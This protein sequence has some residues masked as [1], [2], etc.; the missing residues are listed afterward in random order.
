MIQWIWLGVMVYLLMVFD[1]F[2]VAGVH[3]VFIVLGGRAMRVPTRFDMCRSTMRVPTGL[4][5]TELWGKGVSRE[6]I[7]L[8]AA[9]GARYVSLRYLLLYE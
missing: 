9:A 6:T 7:L 2:T 8:T 4:F 1:F 5:L 3:S